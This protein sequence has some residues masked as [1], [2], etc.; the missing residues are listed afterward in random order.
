MHNAPSQGFAPDRAR[1]GRGVLKRSKYERDQVE[2]Q[3][4]PILNLGR[5][6]T[7]S[8][9]VCEFYTLYQGNGKLIFSKRRGRNASERAYNSSS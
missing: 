4:R 8:L 6:I 3:T 2:E 9:Q 5:A 1:G 7:R